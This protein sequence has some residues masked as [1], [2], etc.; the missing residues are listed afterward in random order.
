MNL[1]R[2]DRTVA[3]LNHFTQPDSIT[4]IYIM[5]G[6]FLLTG[7]LRSHWAITCTYFGVLAAVLTYHI[8]KTLTFVTEFNLREH[9]YDNPAWGLVLQLQLLIA[10]GALLPVTI[11]N[12]VNVSQVHQLPL[13]YSLKQPKRSTRSTDLTIS[14][15]TTGL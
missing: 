11:T 7:C 1:A 5:G 13:Q 12:W 14:S 9:Y 10:L 2:K 3:V 15:S 8:S 4:Y 6:L